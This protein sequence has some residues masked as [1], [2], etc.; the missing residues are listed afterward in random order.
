MFVVFPV[1]LMT[2]MNLRSFRYLERL[3]IKWKNWS[4]Q[5]CQHKTS[6]V[7]FL[8]PSLWKSNRNTM[9]EVPFG[10]TL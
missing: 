5:T 9:M 10:W 8:G 6:E 1:H 4:Y 3:E 2:T 7:E